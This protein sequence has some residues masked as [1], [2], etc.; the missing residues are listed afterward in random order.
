[1]TWGDCYKKAGD[2][3]SAGERIGYIKFGSRV[4]V[5][6]GPEWTAAVQLGDRVSAGTT[7]LA[8]RVPPPEAF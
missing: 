3:L 2:L 5:L 1:M 7:V 8:K 4:D 6:F